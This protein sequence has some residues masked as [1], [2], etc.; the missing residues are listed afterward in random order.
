M[1][2]SL[3]I[4]RKIEAWFLKGHYNSKGPEEL[5]T[6][7]YPNPI[8]SK[9]CTPVK[10]VGG[11]E[12]RIAQ[13]LSKI[14]I[15]HDGVKTKWLGV[16]MSAPQIGISLQICVINPTKPNFNARGGSELME[17]NK[18][19]ERNVEFIFNPKIVGHGKQSDSEKEGC[20]SDPQ[21]LVYKNRWHIIEVEY[22]D[23]TGRKIQA[24]F[25]GWQAKIFQH[26]VDHCQGVLCRD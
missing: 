15:D 6:I 18:K 3:K 23:L 16:G 14:M 8:L 20:L 26:E 9:P 21:T 13:S 7:F 22:L 4:Y 12:L 10:G 17:Q 19:R 5:K 2:K 25:S 11:Y 1:S 24:K